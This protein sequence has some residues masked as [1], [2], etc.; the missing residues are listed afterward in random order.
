MLIANHQSSDW[1]YQQAIKRFSEPRIASQYPSQYHPRHWHDRREKRCIQKALRVIP[2][3]SHILD[4]P[5]GT[6]RLTQLLISQGFRVTGADVSKAMLARARM[7]RSTIHRIAVTAFPGVDFEDHDIMRTGYP[8]DH[9]DAVICNRLFHHF[10]EPTTRLR[11]LTEL[12]RIC[13]GPVIISFFNTFALDAVY[14]RFCDLIR[15]RTPRDRIPIPYK[16]FHT[17]LRLSGFRVL[18]KI[19]LRWGISPHWYVVAI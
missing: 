4:L 10:T 16:T 6:G 1:S 17:E 5:C 18:E 8:D 14:R 13:R 12:R 3:G 9:F 19:A 11:A 2:P 15:G 7:K